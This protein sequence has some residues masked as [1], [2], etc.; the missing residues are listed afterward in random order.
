MQSPSSKELPLVSE[1]AL[2]RYQ[3]LHQHQEN[4]RG[5][6]KKYMLFPGS[7]VI[8]KTFNLK[9]QNSSVGVQIDNYY[10]ILHGHQMQFPDYKQNDD[11]EMFQTV[12]KS[13]FPQKKKS[14]EGQCKVLHYHVEL[15][16]WRNAVNCMQRIWQ[17]KRCNGIAGT[18]FRSS[19][20]HENMPAEFQ[21]RTQENKY[22]SQNKNEASNEEPKYKSTRHQTCASERDF[23]EIKS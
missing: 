6:L 21:T 15:I 11:Q 14:S 12:P 18:F 2:D 20:P 22:V 1:Q 17:F 10:W 23:Q 8:S 4:K 16:C 3:R 9:Q 7:N 13:T 19:H 5:S